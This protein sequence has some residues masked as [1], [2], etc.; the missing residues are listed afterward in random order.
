MHPGSRAGRRAVLLA[1]GLPGICRGIAGVQSPSVRRTCFPAAGFLLS[2]PS[3]RPSHFYRR[4]LSSVACRYVIHIYSSY[5]F[6]ARCTLVQS[7]VLRL[8]VVHPSVCPSVTLV[9]Q[10]HRGWKS[11]KLIARTISPTP[12]LFVAQ[13]PSTYSDGNLGKFWG[14]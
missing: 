5:V 3:V 11:W 14:D 9:D 7:A 2:R 1:A 12:S 10:D 4:V 6:A 13:R 8:H